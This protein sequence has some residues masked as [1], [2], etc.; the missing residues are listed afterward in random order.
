MFS[1]T[2]VSPTYLIES[3]V[4]NNFSSDVNKDWR[5]KA[6]AKAWSFKAKALALALALALKLQ[7][8]ALALCLQAL[9][10]SLA[11]S[12]LSGK[13]YPVLRVWFSPLI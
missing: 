13:T 10:T 7:A 4:T 11:N 6:K 8:L 5:H 1:R 12:L 2:G 9:L 3:T